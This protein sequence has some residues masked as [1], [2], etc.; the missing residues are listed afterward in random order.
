MK[1]KPSDVV[2]C[3]LLTLLFVALALLK[4]VSPTWI[5]G[6]A[7]MVLLSTVAVLTWIRTRRR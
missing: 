3:L 4:P 7:A 2:G 5:A 6:T 1:I